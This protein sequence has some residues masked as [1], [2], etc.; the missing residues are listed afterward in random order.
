MTIIDNYN[1]YVI[2]NASI[3]LTKNVFS[4]IYVVTLHY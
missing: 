1:I 2:K 4:L 3:T